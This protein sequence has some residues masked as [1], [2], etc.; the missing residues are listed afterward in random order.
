M[1]TLLCAI[2]LRTSH[3]LSLVDSPVS[4]ALLDYRGALIILTS[5]GKKREVQ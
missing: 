5:W 3:M 2:L 4:R 1:E